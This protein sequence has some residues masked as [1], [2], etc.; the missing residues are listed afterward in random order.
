MIQ[1]R[2]GIWRAFVWQVTTP[3]AWFLYCLC[4]KVLQIWQFSECGFLASF[5]YSFSVDTWLGH[6]KLFKRYNKYDF[7]AS[8][9]SHTYWGRPRRPHILVSAA[10]ACLLEITNTTYDTRHIL[11]AENSSIVYYFETSNVM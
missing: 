1:I 9:V 4:Y 5:Y 10:P 3:G 2:T 7:L 8:S 11:S 6:Q